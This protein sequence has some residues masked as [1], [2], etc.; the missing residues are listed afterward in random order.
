MQILVG[1]PVRDRAWIL[2][3][4]FD[5]VRVAVDKV[6][7]LDLAFA[8]IGDPR[9]DVE[10]FEVIGAQ[11]EPG[12]VVPFAE[13]GMP[14]PHAWGIDRYHH[15][16]ELRNHLLSRVRVLE[17]DYY[18]SLDSDILAH[19][20]VLV[21]TLDALDSHPQYA[22]MGQ[23]CYMATNDWCT[24][25]AQLT[26]LGGL[27][28]ERVEGVIGVDVIMAAKVMTPAAYRIDYVVHPQGEDIGWSIA[29]REAG[30]RLGWDGRVTSRHVMRRDP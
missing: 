16:V 28:R 23:R 18:W 1:C 13:E 12:H 3:D 26:P 27:V 6:G 4:W 9:T 22:A 19:P 20:D 15:M 30:L 11:P 14:T 8:F 21:S 5:H 17:P 24:S 25:C 2:S 10:T 7:S 29:A